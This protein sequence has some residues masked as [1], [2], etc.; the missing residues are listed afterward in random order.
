MDLE[1]SGR[2]ALVTGA[3]KGIG[4]A[5]ARTLADEGAHVVAVSRTRTAE[6]P[7]K[8]VHVAADLMDPQAPARAVARADRRIPVV[9]VAGRSTLSAARLQQAGIDRAYPLSELEPDQ[10]ASI[11]GAATLLGTVGASITEDWLTGAARS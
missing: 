4:L 9:A 11:A 8:A 1:L 3:S 5:V 6:L 10:T 7:E 2:V